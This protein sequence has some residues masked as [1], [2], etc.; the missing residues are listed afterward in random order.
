MMRIDRAIADAAPAPAAKLADTMF[1][2]HQPAI[3]RFFRRRV[4]DEFTAESLTSDVFCRAVAALPRYRPLRGSALPWLYTIA[5]HR[6]CDHYRTRRPSVSLDA[7]GS[8]A[9]PGSSP[10]AVVELRELVRMVWSAAEQLPASQREALWLRF[11]ED[12]EYPE[13]ARRLGRSVEAVKLLVH[14][15]AK[16]VRRRLQAGGDGRAAAGFP[17]GVGWLATGA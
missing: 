4:R 2:E 9:D 15:G 7:L 10:D 14:R 12:R 16:T 8:V 17:K 13:I 5:A 6:L 3:L 11:G 1:R